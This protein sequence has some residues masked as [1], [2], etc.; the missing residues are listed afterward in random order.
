M[1]KTVRTAH[2]DYSV[3]SS[4]FRQIIEIRN[5][6]TQIQPECAKI[7]LLIFVWKMTPIWEQH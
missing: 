4:G 2:D 7:K 5:P 6:N 3:L 1:H